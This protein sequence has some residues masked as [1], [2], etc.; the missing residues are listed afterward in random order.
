MKRFIFPIT[1]LL[2]LSLALADVDLGLPCSTTDDCTF[3]LNGE[4][5]Y[6]DETCFAS[7]SPEE[8]EEDNFNNDNNPA[9][10]QA[11]PAI[12]PEDLRTQLEL[13]NLTS[14]INKTEL[15]EL[16]YT[17]E[18]LQG[19]SSSVEERL[20]AI[21]S[22]YL[23]L[24]QGYGGI[25]EQLIQIQ[26]AIND[27]NT[28]LQILNEEQSSSKQQINQKVQG[29]ATGLAGLQT[30]VE[31]TSSNL[32]NVQEE[33]ETEK[34][35]TTFFTVIFVMLLAMAIFAGIYLYVNKNKEQSTPEI[36]S[37]IVNYI[38][39]HIKT[40]KKFPHIKEN[41]LKA[42]W[43]EHDINWAYKETLKQN[44]KTYLQGSAPASI[45]ASNAQQ[46][47]EP[48]Q[49][50][51]SIPA[52]KRKAMMIGIVSVFVILGILLLLRGVTTGHAIYFQTPDQFEKAVHDKIEESIKDN[53]F[54]DKVDYLAL[55][56]QVNDQNNAASYKITKTPFDQ[57]MEPAPTP[58][59]Q[60]FKYDLSIKFSSFEAFE[61]V[62]EDLTCA[63]ARK[64][65]GESKN[66]GAYVLPSRL[67]L[68]GF[69]ANPT[70]SYETYCKLMKDCLTDAEV[71]LIGI[72]C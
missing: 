66:G 17:L 40:G 36:N 24:E 55:C 67:V 43:S 38:T 61:Y 25:Q 28:Q 8:E 5:G 27:L 13:L 15:S 47:K 23:T 35:F 63:A 37:E 18:Y 20:A 54:N 60:D 30:E 7:D 58:C 51:Q 62:S 57:S 3:F 21:E 39:K 9:N 48:R 11:P 33:L 10:N 52:D 44:Y 31:S 4:P 42:G 53:E 72:K 16:R 29:V 49:D 2:V 45:Q 32:D 14:P 46:T 56:V 69:K 50:P 22:G 65:H 41:L 34:S 1:L 59:D 12:N 19:Q 6:C 71:A 64:V 68:P 26:T 70:V